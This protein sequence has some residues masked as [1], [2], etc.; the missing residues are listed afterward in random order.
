MAVDARGA[1]IEDAWTYQVIEKRSGLL[2]TSAYMDILRSAAVR[3]EFPED[4]I[5]M[6]ETIP[7]VEPD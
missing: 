3:Y 1:G 4:Y 6:L 7:V 5:A 2:P